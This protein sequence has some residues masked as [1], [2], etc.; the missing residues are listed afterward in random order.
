MFSSYLRISRGKCNILEFR[1]IFIMS[2]LRVFFLNQLSAHCLFR[3]V[4]T[5]KMI[6]IMAIR[7]KE[8]VDI[9]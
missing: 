9:S 8:A 2:V 4:I 6:A 1:D 3:H 7:V 5:R